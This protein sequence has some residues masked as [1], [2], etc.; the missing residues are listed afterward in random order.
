[1]DLKRGEEAQ[2]D[3]DFFV[4]GHETKKFGNTGLIFNSEL[5]FVN[6]SYVLM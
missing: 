6:S 4:R 3:T 2:L 5:N 1:M